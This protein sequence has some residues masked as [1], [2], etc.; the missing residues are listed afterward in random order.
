MRKGFYWLAVTGLLMVSPQA[1]T[2]ASAQG[3][4]SV[5]QIIKQLTPKDAGESEERTRSFRTRGI[6]SVN[7]PATPNRP[8]VV[9]QVKVDLQTETYFEFNKAELTAHGKAE[10]DNYI[11]ALTSRSLLPFTFRIVGHTDDVGSYEYNDELSLK[12]ANAVRDYMILRNV[13]PRRLEV[14]GEG[15]RRLKNPANPTGAENRRVEIV[16]IGKSSN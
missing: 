11:K 14:L 10:I 3:A 16:N 4:P 2:G 8:K 12:R 15:K 13:D 1:S 9:E 5:D 6:S 7:P